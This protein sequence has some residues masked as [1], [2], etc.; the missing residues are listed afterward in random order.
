M[1]PHV[2]DELD[3]LAV[4]EDFGCGRP[5]VVRDEAIAAQLVDQAAQ[6]CVATAD[7]RQHGVQIVDD[8]PDDVFP[9]RDCLA[10]AGCPA[11]F[12]KK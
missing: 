5:G 4:A 12:V 11:F 10:D 9:A 1:A 6:L 2:W 8:P 3:E 7:R